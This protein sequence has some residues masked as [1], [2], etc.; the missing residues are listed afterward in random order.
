MF[1]V[2]DCGVDFNRYSFLRT[3][4]FSETVA[5]VIYFALGFVVCFYLFSTGVL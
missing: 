3:I 5:K 4:M 2:D 1:T